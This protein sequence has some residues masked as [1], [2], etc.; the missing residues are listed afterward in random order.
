MWKELNWYLYL[1]TG[2]CGLG[3]W[4]ASRPP[5]FSD[6][7]E[8]WSKGSYTA[9]ELATAFSVT[10]F[11][12]NNTWSIGQNAPPTHNVSAHHCLYTSSFQPFC[13]SGTPRM[14]SSGSRN[15][16]SLI[17]S[18]ELQYTVAC[19]IFITS[20]GPLDCAGGGLGFRG[21]PAEN[22]CSTIS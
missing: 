4:G 3:V 5:V 17:C 19:S 7:Q 14:Y 15:P 16:F 10:F 8:S 9:R 6:L 20:G 18:G 21:T 13:W 11:L 2:M 1:Y 22:H 12:S